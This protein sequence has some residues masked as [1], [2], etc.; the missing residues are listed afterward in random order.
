MCESYHKMPTNNF[1]T[2]FKSPKKT[3]KKKKKKKKKKGSRC[4]FNAFIFSVFIKKK[5]HVS[6][7]EE[8]LKKILKKF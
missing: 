6:I 8:N 1:L 4:L 3:Q 7:V 5:Y 2:I